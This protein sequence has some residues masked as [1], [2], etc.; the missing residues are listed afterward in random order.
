MEAG[1]TELSAS[2]EESLIIITYLT[3]QIENSY[4]NV[5]LARW[6]RSLR[7]LNQEFKQMDQDSYFKHYE[8][9]IKNILAKPSTV[10]RILVLQSDPDVVFG[11]CVYEN[12]VLHYMH[13][14]EPY[15]GQKYSYLLIPSHIKSFTHRTSHW[16]DR[17]WKGKDKRNN[18]KKLKDLIYNPFA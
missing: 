3:K 16:N 5:I 15:R 8:P 4:R 9:F 12:D 7:T 6:L 17:L 14:Q 13:I 18:Q 11:W 10:A 2:Q 1:T